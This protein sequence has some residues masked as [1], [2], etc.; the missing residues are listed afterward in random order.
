MTGTLL[1]YAEVN[2][3]EQHESV[4][5]WLHGLGDSGNGFAPIVP[6]LNLPDDHKIRFV[7]P[8]APIRPVTIN[9][10]MPMRAWYD[11]KTMDFN[12]RA[13]LEG[14]LESA[15]EVERLLNAEIEKGIPAEK[16]VLA[17]FSQGGVIAYHLGLRLDKSLAGI[18]ALSTYMC[19]PEQLGNEA[20]DANRNTPIFVGHGQDDEVVPM[21][22]GKAAFE[23]LEKNN[24]QAQWQEYPMQHNVCLQELKDI[25]AW[26]KER[27]L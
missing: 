14:V 10:G 11:I 21:S 3:S 9:N 12:N 20:H 5:I 25:S 23:V 1:P 4:V 15:H 8:H 13:D 18:L 16:I 2:P 22:M 6:E 19:K 27:L 26:L 24:Y 17:G 7:F